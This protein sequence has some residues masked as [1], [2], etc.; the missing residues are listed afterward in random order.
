MCAPH[1][2]DKVPLDYFSSN[3]NMTSPTISQLANLSSK[4]LTGLFRLP[5]P[6]SNFQTLPDTI[7]KQKINKLILNYFIQ[8]GFQKAALTFSKD[9]GIDLDENLKVPLPKLSGALQFVSSANLTPVDFVQAVKKYAELKTQNLNT[10]ASNNKRAEYGSDTMKGYSSIDKRKKIK[11]LILKGDITQAI[12]VIS[13]YFPTVL[14]CNNL[15]LFKLLRLNLIE[16]IRDH[17]FETEN[18]KKDA[19]EAEKQF[20]DDILLFVRENLVNKVTHSYELLKELEMTMSLLC[21]NFNPRKPIEELNDLPEELGQLFDLSL[22]NECYRVVNRIIL[23]LEYL[24]LDTQQYK[25]LAYADFSASMLQKLP[26]APPLDSQED[27]EMVDA[28]LNSEAEHLDYSEY[29]AAYVPPSR[30]DSLLAP[31]PVQEDFRPENVMLESYLERIAMLWIAT[32]QRL[33]EKKIIPAKRYG[34]ENKDGLC[35]L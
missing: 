33:M 8:E 9:T 16:M 12:H 22:R 31:L 19:A 5:A 7:S 23:D 1:S 2:I 6:G 15:L 3:C 4:Q 11:Y 13:T 35:Y 26:A 18:L 30:E 24:E 25:G 21:F 29:V 34:L 14:D 28:E 10:L 17:K 20:L 27:V 32:E